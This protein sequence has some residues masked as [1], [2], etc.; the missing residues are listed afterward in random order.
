MRIVGDV[1]RETNLNV[2]Y[3]MLFGPPVTGVVI[4][5]CWYPSSMTRFVANTINVIGDK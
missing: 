1:S 3:D 5:S 4:P 2:D